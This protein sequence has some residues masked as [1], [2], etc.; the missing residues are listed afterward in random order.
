M[1]KWEGSTTVVYT[2]RSASLPISGT[3][4]YLG[5]KTYDENLLYF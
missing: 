2:V 4:F 5:N 1:K 3:D